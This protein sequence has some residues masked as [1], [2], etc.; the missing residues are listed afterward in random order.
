MRLSTRS[1]I[2]VLIG[3]SAAYAM[4]AAASMN[5]M[6]HH[7]HPMPRIKESKGKRNSKKY[8]PKK[9]ANKGQTNTNRKGHRR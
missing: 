9:L 4:Q 1:G 2:L 3:I 7:V 8:P 5:T 6:S